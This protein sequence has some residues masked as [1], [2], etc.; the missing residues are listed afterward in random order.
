MGLNTDKGE[1]EGKLLQL[2]QL[3]QLIHKKK[4]RR[5]WLLQKSRGSGGKSSVTSLQ[6]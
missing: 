6:T 5:M 3:C 1:Y 4:S 2:A